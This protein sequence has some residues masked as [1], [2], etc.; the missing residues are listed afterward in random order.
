MLESA[1]TSPSF[2]GLAKGSGTGR[3]G[4]Q[5]SL[6]PPGQRPQRRESPHK[7]PAA[8]CSLTA[9]WKAHFPLPPGAAAARAN[10]CVGHPRLLRSS[11]RDGARSS[12]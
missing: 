8:G 7:P 9:V 4:M 12:S 1:G 3:G 5:A 2:L 10:R 11:G 6:A